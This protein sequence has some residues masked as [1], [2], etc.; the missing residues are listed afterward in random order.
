MII[1]F[2]WQFSSLKAS[3]IREKVGEKKKILFL[4]QLLLLGL[5]FK[6]RNKKNIIKC[7]FV[8]TN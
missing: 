5:L 4:N 7:V 1:I 8:V 6:Y 2:H 3:R